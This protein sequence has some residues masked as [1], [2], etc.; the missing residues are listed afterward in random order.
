VLI[1]LLVQPLTS[2]GWNLE[3]SPVAYEF[4]DVTRAIQNRAA[5]ST[6]LKVGGHNGT[7][8]GIHFVVKIVG[9]LA[10]YF[11]AVDFDGLLGQAVPPF[12]NSIQVR[13]QSYGVRVLPGRNLPLV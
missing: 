3:S 12:A 2:L 1:E 11:F 7:E 8:T 5:V 4:Y 9:N 6:I 10:P 13:L